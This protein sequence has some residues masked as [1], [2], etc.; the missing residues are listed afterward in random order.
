MALKYEFN[1]GKEKPEATVIVLATDCIQA[2]EIAN[3]AL[4]DDKRPDLVPFCLSF[5]C[6]GYV[7]Y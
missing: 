5:R 7:E 1:Y 3:K 6:F 2:R 4:I